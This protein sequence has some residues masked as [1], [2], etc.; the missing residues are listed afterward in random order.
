MKKQAADKNGEKN[1]KETRKFGVNELARMMKLE[2]PTVR[3]KLRQSKIKRAGRGY[4]WNS[5]AE[6]KGIAKKLGAAAA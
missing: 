2:P 5:E 6:M 1:K 4:S 3:I